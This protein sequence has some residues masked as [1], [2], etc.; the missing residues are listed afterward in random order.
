[1][2]LWYEEYQGILRIK[3]LPLVSL[4]HLRRSSE[5]VTFL[6]VFEQTA[7]LNARRRVLVLQ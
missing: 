6:S 4:S 1:M 5:A 2:Q 7:K 3:H